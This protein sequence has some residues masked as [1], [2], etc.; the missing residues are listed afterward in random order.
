MVRRDSALASGAIDASIW[1][2]SSRVGARIS[3]GGEPD[4]HGQREGVGLAGPG[5]PATEHVAPGQRV[6]QRRSLDGE[7]G[8]DALVRQ[9]RHQPGRHT[10]LGEARTGDR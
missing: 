5:P 1:L 6:R 10:Q 3:A 4:E 9:G 2:T 8:D 7:R